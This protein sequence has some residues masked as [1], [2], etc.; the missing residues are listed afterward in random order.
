MH[1]ARAEPDRREHG[2][3]A[4]RGA[5]ACPAG[6]S[7][8]VR[9]RGRP[10]VA[11]GRLGI[12]ASPLAP[13]G[14]VGA[15]ALDGQDARPGPARRRGRQRSEDR[16]PVAAAPRRRR[17]LGQPSPPGHG[18]RTGRRPHHPAPPG[19]SACRRTRGERHASKPS[20]AA[21]ASR[22]RDPPTASTSGCRWPGT[23]RSSST[24]WPDGGG[25]SA[26]AAPMPSTLLMVQPALRVTTSTMSAHDAARFAEALAGVLQP[27][28]SG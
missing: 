21:T 17:Q 5:P 14:A 9:D 16:G 25:R 3:R 28:R 4:S 12:R 11:R 22:Q 20:C 6:L 10:P 18:G 23:R 27:E 2:R 26:R 24:S 19:R 1:V 7:G 8:G 15:G 13:H